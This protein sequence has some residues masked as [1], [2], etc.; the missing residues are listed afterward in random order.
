MKEQKRVMGESG[1]RGG[2][3]AERVVR[4]SSR[5]RISE[6]RTDMTNATVHSL[7]I[8]TLTEH[9]SAGHYTEEGHGFISR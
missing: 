9:R 6:P 8:K 3:A 1:Q 4:R 2:A 5:G 7:Y